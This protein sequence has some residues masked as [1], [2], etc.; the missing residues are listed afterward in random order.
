MAESCS[1]GSERGRRQRNQRSQGP[2]SPVSLQAS[3][4]TV[5][6]FCQEKT[7]G[8]LKN[9]TQVGVMGREREPSRESKFLEGRILLLCVWRKGLSTASLT[10]G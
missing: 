1:G 4:G 5:K 7:Q 9:N 10:F 8:Y 2:L 3:L 6:Q